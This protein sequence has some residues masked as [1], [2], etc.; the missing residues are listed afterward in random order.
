[1]KNNM[2]IILS[3][4][5]LFT[6]L[7]YAFPLRK[8]R[9]GYQRVLSNFSLAI[10][11]MPIT[12]LLILPF[13]IF[14][15]H[16]A[17]LKGWGIL[18]TLKINNTLHSVLGFFILDYTLYWWHVANHRINIFWRFHQ[19]HHADRDMDATT[20]LR[21]HFGELTFSAVLR[22]GLILIVGFK[23]ETI[24]FFDVL[25]TSMALFH[26]SNFKLPLLAENF[27]SLVIVTPLYHQNHHSYYWEE[28]N[29]NF[30]TIF[31]FWDRIHHS[32]SRPNKPDD[33]TIGH[34]AFSA[35]EIHLL[36]LIKMPFKSIRNWPENLRKRN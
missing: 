15:S 8:R 11:A 3:I 5:S 27:F 30:S 29:S 9:D 31:S 14:V 21:F 2:V 22:S 10:L 25:V 24:L 6:V 17:E 36:A 18:N 33:V 13:I 28:T 20:A 35:N 1:M 12:R 34:P 4:L 32:Y 16:T 26:H 7:E 19:V 23:I